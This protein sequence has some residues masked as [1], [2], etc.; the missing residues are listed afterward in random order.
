MAGAIWL[1]WRKAVVLWTAAGAM[2][3]FGAVDVVEVI[4][5]LAIQHPTLVTVAAVVAALHFLAAIL[6]VRLVLTRAG[7]EPVH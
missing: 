6:A 5:Q 7:L 1:Y 4:H 3:A 2:F